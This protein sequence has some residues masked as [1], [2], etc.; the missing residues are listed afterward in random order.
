LI[1][2]VKGQCALTPVGGVG[3]SHGGYKGYNWATLVELLSIA[4]QS[5]PIGQE[6]SGID[7]ETG[8]PAPMPLGHYFLAINIE[9][10]CDLE[11]FKQN[12]GNLMRMIRSSKK[13]PR[14]P[15]K[16]W[17]AGEPE[18]DFRCARMAAGG[19]IVP[20]ILLQ[21]MKELRDKLP[22]LQ[23]KYERFVFE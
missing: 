11:T 8:K 21:E 13:D 5:G 7:R 20:P 23:Q 9:A 12:A 22:D 14:G 3:D 15:G 6:L 17:T 16:I 18:W 1:D 4:F 2:M 19:T 10:L